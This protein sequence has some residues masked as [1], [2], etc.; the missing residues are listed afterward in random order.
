MSNIFIDNSVLSWF[1]NYNS[2]CVH[3]CTTVVTISFYSGFTTG[4][5]VV[6]SNF[7]NI[8]VYIHEFMTFLSVQLNEFQQR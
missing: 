1:S 5:T 2:V 7:F 3:L 6:F 8:T 4:L